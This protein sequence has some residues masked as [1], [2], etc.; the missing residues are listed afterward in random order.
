[1]ASASTADFLSGLA[2][3]LSTSSSEGGNWPQDPVAALVI[4]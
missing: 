4:P 2:L 1:M 3:R